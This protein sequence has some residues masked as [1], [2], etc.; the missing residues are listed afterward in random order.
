MKDV[1][2]KEAEYND[3]KGKIG[4]LIYRGSGDPVKHLN[5]A[6]EQYTKGNQYNEFVD[7]NMDNPW[8]RIIVNTQ[9]EFFI[10][11][12]NTEEKENTKEKEIDYE[13]IMKSFDKFEKSILR[14]KQTAKDFLI[15]IGL[16]DEYDNVLIKEEIKEENSE[17]EKLL[18]E[19]IDKGGELYHRHFDGLQMPNIPDNAVELEHRDTIESLTEKI[20]IKM[21]WD[22]FKINNIYNKLKT[23]SYGK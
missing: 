8:F 18:K 23:K 15:K 3:G 12:R 4:I 6:V 21:S 5:E 2:I 22:F 9:D 7:A 10:P 20:K 14:S 16:I 13:E 17:F 1:I 19:F 11:V